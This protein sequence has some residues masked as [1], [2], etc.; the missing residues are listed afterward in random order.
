MVMKLAVTNSLCSPN[1]ISD[2][3]AKACQSKRKTDAESVPV[4]TVMMTILTMMSFD[5][6]R[7]AFQSAGSEGHLSS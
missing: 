7:R 2:T 1:T 5:L 6:R 4:A 3:T